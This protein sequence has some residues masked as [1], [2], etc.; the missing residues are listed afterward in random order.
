MHLRLVSTRPHSQSLKRLSNELTSRLGR[1][2]VRSK[3][4]RINRLNL[5]YG[6]CHDKLSQYKWFKE[7]E[8]QSLPFTTDK[9]QANNWLSEGE[10]VFARTLITAS[11]G[12]GIVVLESPE[13]IENVS[14]PV[15]TKY[16]PKKKEYRVHIFK[17][18]VIKVLEKRRTSGNSP[19][20]IRNT[21]NGYVF[22]RENV[23]EPDGIRELALKA[24]GVTKSDFCGV[25]IGY[26]EKRNLLFVIECNSAPGIEGSNIIDYCDEIIKHV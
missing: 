17:D 14:A 13:E 12:R 10:T 19:S 1:K 11:E 9:S 16:I 8:V 24:R 6:D 22:C 15:Y 20:K 26:N 3:S 7:N 25:D 21:A 23:V 4:P 2:V 18:R 5:I